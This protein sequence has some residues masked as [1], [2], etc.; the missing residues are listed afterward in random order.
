MTFTLTILLLLAVTMQGE[1]EVLDNDAAALAVYEVAMNRVED[2]RFPDALH[3]V[4]VSGF[5]GW[6]RLSPSRLD[7]RYLD[8]AATALR[9]GHNWDHKALYML[10]VDDCRG[11][12]ADTARAVRSYRRGRWAVYL[13]EEWPR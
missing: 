4:L 10:S 9:S 5:N 6:R 13:Y 8:L 3:E 12:G 2:S 7:E 11:L 1:V